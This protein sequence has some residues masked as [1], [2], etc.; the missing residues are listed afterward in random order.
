[1]NTSGFLLLF[2]TVLVTV[3]SHKILPRE[4]NDRS[5]FVSKIVPFLKKENKSLFWC[6]KE[7]S[8]SKRCE[9]TQLLRRYIGFFLC[10]G[11]NKAYELYLKYG[12]I[13]YI[14]H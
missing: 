1:M 3:R 14:M 13:D 6:K 7:N 2:T 9:N 10:S 5:V 11:D 8:D 4:E 12:F